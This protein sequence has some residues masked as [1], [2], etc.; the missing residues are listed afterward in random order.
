[1][2][3]LDGRTAVAG[4][5]SLLDL[6]VHEIETSGPM[7][8]SRYVDLALYEPELGFYATGGAG[9]RR[10]FITSPEVGPLFGAV[11]GRA[12]DTWW[13]ELGGPDPFT[14]VEVGAG[15]GALA[16]A[17]L[18]AAPRCA[19][20][21]RYVAVESSA[22]QRA[23]H[24]AGIESVADLPGPVDVGVVFANELLDNLPFDVL[25]FDSGDGW[26]EIRVGVAPDGGLAEVTVPTGRGPE[27]VAG[28]PPGSLR[29]PDLVAARSWLTRAL[30]TI[31]RGRVVVIDY[32]VPS[33]PVEPDRAWL[34]T[35]RNHERG[36]D[37]LDQPGSQDITIDVAIDQLA[38]VRT[39]DHVRSQGIWLRRHGIDELVEEGRR[40]WHEHAAAPD[41][42]ALRHR[43]RV[44]ESEALLDPGGLGAFSVLEWQVS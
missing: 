8:Y 24:P 4:E 27:L 14:F 10:D 11:V 40:Y 28:T 35:Y 5:R 34:R 9:R 1:M 2:T 20:A 41:V 32:A 33:Y 38:A 25:A 18:A 23:R 19:S 26:R 7:A 39:P 44:P 36:G 29:I 43:S 6:V 15:P 37:P 21:L 30:A 22:E 3:R 17:V 31:R 42:A 12:L 16:R 13:D